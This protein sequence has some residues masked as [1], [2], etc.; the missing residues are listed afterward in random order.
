MSTA[1]QEW[2]TQLPLPQPHN[3]ALY[4]ADGTLTVDWHTAPYGYDVSLVRGRNELLSQLAVNPPT[5]LPMD[6]LP[7]GQYCVIVNAR[8]LGQVN[9]AES[10][11]EPCVVKLDT[12]TQITLSFNEESQRLEV[13][14]Q[15]VLGASGYRVQLVHLV[16]EETVPASANSWLFVG[17]ASADSPSPRL[18]A[19]VQAKGDDRYYVDSNIGKSAPFA[20]PVVGDHWGIFDLTDFDEVRFHPEGELPE[21]TSNGSIWTGI[22][23]AQGQVYLDGLPA[24]LYSISFPDLDAA[25]WGLLE[26][27]SLLAP[28]A[29]NGSH[30]GATEQWAAGGSDWLVFELVDEDGQ[31]VVG[32]RYIVTRSNG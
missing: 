15:P 13:N 31:P 18:Q 25:D 24:G 16:A 4:H 22:T 2:L 20:V 12:P 17:A 10:E 6:A 30:N 14:W 9:G 27:N 3:I 23:D 29:V 1:G 32:E 5:T 8:T 7:A 19:W 26:S 11:I 28:A 21:P